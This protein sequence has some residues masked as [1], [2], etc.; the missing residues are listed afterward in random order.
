[1]TFLIIN[2]AN[3]KFE[4][5]PGVRKCFANDEFIDAAKGDAGEFVGASYRKA[6]KRGGQVGIVTQNLSFL[7]EIDPLVRKSIIQNTKIL[8]LLD[9]KEKRSEAYPVFEKYLSLTKF[10][11]Q[12]MDSLEDGRLTDKRFVEFFLKLGPHARVFRN[13]VSPFAEGVFTTSENEI[14]RIKKLHEATGNLATAINQFAEE[15]Y[16][17]LNR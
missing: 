10:D 17:S 7:E 9:H 6:R 4:H 11:L 8:F 5:T 3:D 1:M 2:L 14:L 13:E 16:G 12:L 15:K